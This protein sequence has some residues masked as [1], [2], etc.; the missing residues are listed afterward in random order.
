MAA[1]FTLQLTLP[2]FEERRA[3]PQ[4]RAKELRKNTAR[5]FC[6]IL[7]HDSQKE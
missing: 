3:V 5:T 2:Y 4:K 1:S 7:T 6:D